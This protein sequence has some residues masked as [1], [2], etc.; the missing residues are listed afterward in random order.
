MH[1]LGGNASGAEDTSASDRESLMGMLARA[2]G[3]TPPEATAPVAPATITAPAVASKP[4]TPPP[5]E[6]SRDQ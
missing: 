1:Q 4:A 5:V 6:V 2:A 3:G